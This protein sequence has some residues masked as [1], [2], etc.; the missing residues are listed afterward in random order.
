MSAKAF[1]AL[2]KSSDVSSV[3]QTAQS[4]VNQDDEDRKKILAIRKRNLIRF[5]SLAVL[6]FVVWL[7]AT[8]SWFTANRAVETSG[9]GVKSATLP[10]DIAT[11]GARVR[12][13][14]VMNAQKPEYTEGASGTYSDVNNS[15]GT[16]YVGDSLLLRFD[17]ARQDDSQTAEDESIPPDISPGS[18]GEL[19]LYV[20]PK[21]N[22]SQKVKV[23]L[24]VV[25]FAEID[26]YDVS[27]ET[28]TNSET[29]EVEEE[30]V[31]TKNGTQIIEITNSADFATAA[32]AVNNSTAAGEAEKYIAAADYLKGHILFFGGLGETTTTPG[33]SG[34]E[35][36]WNYYYTAPYTSRTINQTIASGNEGKAV[37]VPI[38]WMWTN[39]L[40][41]IALQT[42]TYNLRSGIPVVQETAVNLNDET[43]TDKE[44]LLAYLET[45]KSTVFTGTETITHNMIYE[46]DT[47]ENFETLSKQYNAADYE[48][49]T[50]IT[51]FMI[52]VTV[53]SDS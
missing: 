41:Q 24:N 5:G 4:Q 9:M 1:D 35:T 47:L 13:S 38:Y 44:L 31:Y 21:T 14:T 39:T 18:S 11:K 25:A 30:T 17:P 49:G 10:F 34:S 28:V 2:S 50:R 16:Y 52:D 26:K 37:Q 32:N 22:E 15:E 33:S 23:S 7:F 19:S 53:E 48:I 43:V 3:P 40:G 27:T 8:I 42:N 36:V 20:I 51:Y 45:N 29:D 6:A 12:N 46:A